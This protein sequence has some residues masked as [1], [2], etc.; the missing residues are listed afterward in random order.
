MYQKYDN[1]SVYLIE[2]ANNYASSWFLHH[3]H[4]R[5]KLSLSAHLSL[6]RLPSLIQKHDVIFLLLLLPTGVSS[7][8]F[9][10]LVFPLWYG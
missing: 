4:F 10:F 5:G 2:I 9:H 6:L 8:I 1:H 3:G 7:L